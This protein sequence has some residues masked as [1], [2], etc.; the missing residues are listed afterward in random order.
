MR[1]GKADLQKTVAP[2]GAE[3]LSPTP[4]IQQA[5]HLPSPSLTYKGADLSIALLQ[6]AALTKAHLEYAN[7]SGADLTGALLTDAHLERTELTEA[8]LED[9]KLLE[10]HLEGAIFRAARLGGAIL[11]GVSSTLHLA[12]RMPFS[13]VMAMGSRQ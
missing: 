7:L 5:V 1:S 11:R 9:S 8:R 2:L 12:S 4:P 3:S 6:G 10:T 13:A